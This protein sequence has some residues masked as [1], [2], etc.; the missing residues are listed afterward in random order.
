MHMQLEMDF[1]PTVTITDK[2]VTNRQYRASNFRTIADNRKW[3]DVEGYY[4]PILGW[5]KV[6]NWDRINQV[7]EM[8]WEKIT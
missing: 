6:K 8:L 2:H 4:G 5:R 7:A 1:Q 3:A